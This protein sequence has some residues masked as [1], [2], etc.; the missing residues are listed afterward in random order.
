MFG[1]CRAAS[2][3]VV[4]GCTIGD[5][6]NAGNA[7]ISGVE[8][9]YNSSW[10]SAG[11]NQMT[12][13]MAYTLTNAEFDTTFDSDFWG[14][15]TKGMDIPNTPSSQLALVLGTDFQNGWSADARA[16]Y[17]GSTCSVAECSAFTNIAVSYTHL[18]LPTKA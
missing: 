2:S 3:G 12:A 6:F 7:T 18:T 14:S 10:Q 15:V 4:E 11:G 13:Q 16:L 8:L 9:S 5:T 1:E 17:Y